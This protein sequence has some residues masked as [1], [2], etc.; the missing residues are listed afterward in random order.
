MNFEELM[1]KFNNDTT[2]VA[3]AELTEAIIDLKTAQTT[4]TRELV[5]QIS[6]IAFI[7]H[8]SDI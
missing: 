6:E 3:I 1:E 5:K 4:H 8:N 7:L 2:A